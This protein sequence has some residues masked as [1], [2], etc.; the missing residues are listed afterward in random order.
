MTTDK[1]TEEDVLSLAIMLAEELGYAWNSS[2]GVI[3]LCPTQRD[4]IR[5]ARAVLAAYQDRE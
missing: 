4:F 3:T 2:D 1:P 5:A